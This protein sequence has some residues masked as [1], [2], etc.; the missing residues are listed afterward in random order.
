GYEPRRWMVAA[1]V[2][3]WGLRLG[4]YLLFTRVIGHPEEGRYVHLRQKWKTNISLKFLIFF[5]VQALLDVIL[6]V[7]F[8]LAARNQSP[9]IHPLE[10]LALA[11][12]VVSIAGESLA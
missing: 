10:W 8:L 11:V 7:P 6:S 2:G 1:M 9:K 3:V 4:A 12:W 5:Q